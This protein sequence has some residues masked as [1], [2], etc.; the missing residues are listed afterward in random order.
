MTTEFLTKFFPPSKT[1]EFRG[2]INPFVLKDK[3][4]LFKSWKRFMDPL[5]DCPHHGI[6]KIELLKIHFKGLDEETQLKLQSL[7]AGDFMDTSVYEAWEFIEKQ[8]LHMEKYS[9]RRV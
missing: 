8:A 2:K 7:S 1:A 6:P 3:E 5:L 4:S 9:H